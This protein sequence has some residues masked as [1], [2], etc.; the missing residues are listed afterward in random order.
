ML[1]VDNEINFE[2]VCSSCTAAL[3]W[4]KLASINVKKSSTKNGELKA[5][6]YAIK[7]K[8]EQQILMHG[9]PKLCC[10]IAVCHGQKSC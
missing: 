10:C 6:F 7:L 4:I 3:A 9:S 8:Q 2:V 5:E 1:A